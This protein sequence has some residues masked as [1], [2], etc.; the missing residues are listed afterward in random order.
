MPIEIVDRL[1]RGINMAVAV[2]ATRKSSMNFKLF[3]FGMLAE[4]T[5]TIIMEKNRLELFRTV[6][7]FFDEA[8]GP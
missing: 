7:A 6:Q 2:E 8:G 1:N 5:H 3:V 4:G